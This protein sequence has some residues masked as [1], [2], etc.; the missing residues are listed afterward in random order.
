MAPL[1]SRVAV[2]GTGLIGGSFALANDGNALVVIKQGGFGVPAV[3]VWCHGPCHHHAAPDGSYSGVTGSGDG[4]ILAL[5]PSGPVY[6][7]FSDTLVSVTGQVG[8]PGTAD[9]VGDKIQAG[10][11][12]GPAVF[13][14]AIGGLVVQPAS[15]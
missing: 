6:H 2:L 9:L 5:M 15:Q 14:A 3:S 7:A 4:S 12:D 13:I 10:T 1:F 11:P 8:S